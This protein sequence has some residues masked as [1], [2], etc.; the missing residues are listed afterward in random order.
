MGLEYS[1]SQQMGKSGESMEP[2]GSSTDV[3]YGRARRGQKE[4]ELGVWATRSLRR[5]KARIV[6]VG[7]WATRSLRRLK[8]RIVSVG[9]KREYPQE[10]AWMLDD[11]AQWE[12]LFR[13]EE[14]F[15]RSARPFTCSWI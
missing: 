6:S 3:A 5:L 10:K 13:G 14:A 2:S 11:A 4:N 1:P 12:L 8:A 9:G 15:W 7:G